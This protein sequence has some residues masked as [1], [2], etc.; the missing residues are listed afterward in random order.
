MQYIQIDRGLISRITMNREALHNAFNETMIQ[1]I[2]SAFDEFSND[3]HSRVLIL[4]SKGPSFSAGAD[5]NWMKK[6]INYTKDENE[7]DSQELFSMLKA[8]S[9][10]PIP[11]ISRIQ[12]SALGGG[13]GLVA[14]TDMAFSLQSAKFGFTEVKLGLIPAVIS[15]FVRDKIGLNQCRRYFFTGE[16]FDATTAQIIGLVNEVFSTEEE[17]DQTIDKI[18]QNIIQSSSTAV[19]SAKHLINN[20]KLR[21]LEECRNYVCRSIA[22]ARVSADGQKG[23]RGFLQKKSVDWS[24]C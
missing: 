19:K 17:M 2:K 7:A 20:I 10:C 24:K 1:E 6:M 5:L 14:A 15:P 18:C 3:L 8:I 12:G 22:E 23:I 16:R 13:C 11:T 21:P 4:D 9:D